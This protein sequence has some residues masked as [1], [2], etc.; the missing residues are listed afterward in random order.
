MPQKRMLYCDRLEH[1]VQ[2]VPDLFSKTT[3]LKGTQYISGN[4]AANLEHV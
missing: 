4:T 3:F 2:T 1:G